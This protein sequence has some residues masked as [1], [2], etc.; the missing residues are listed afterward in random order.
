[1]PAYVSA[2]KYTDDKLPGAKAGEGKA[3]I[4]G[5]EISVGGTF[6]Y[7]FW[8][9]YV[10]GP[11]VKFWSKKGSAAAKYAVATLAD[12]HF[13]IGKIVGDC[14]KACA[15]TTAVTGMDDYGKPSLRQDIAPLVTLKPGCHKAYD[16]AQSGDNEYVTIN[17]KYTLNKEEYTYNPVKK[18][19]GSKYTTVT[20]ATYNAEQNQVMCPCKSKTES[21]KTWRVEDDL[22][23]AHL[24]VCV[25]DTDLGTVV[26]SVNATATHAE[27]KGVFQDDKCSKVHKTL[28]VDGATAAT[29]SKTGP[30]IFGT[31]IKVENPAANTKFSYKV[32]SCRAKGV[33]VVEEY[34]KKDDC[35]G[36]K[37]KIQTV[38]ATHAKQGGKTCDYFPLKIACST[39]P[40]QSASYMSL[41][42]MVLVFMLGMAL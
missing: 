34:T 30:Q 23:V 20:A 39:P 22:S 21:R 7:A 5:L 40:A 29:F 14:R 8:Q 16:V 12:E 9:E 3:D 18:W 38:E 2:P 24:D 33:V 15:A 35:S 42:A 26:A 6:K 19:N 25:A 32:K 1:M 37:R 10:S 13:K 31:C 4:V 41:P 11:K 17:A 36:D 28:L 27:I